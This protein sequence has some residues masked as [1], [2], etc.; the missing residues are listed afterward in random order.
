MRLSENP[1]VRTQLRLAR[2]YAFWPI[3]VIGALVAAAAVGSFAI[4]YAEKAA[5]T[6]TTARRLASYARGTYGIFFAFEMFVLAIG[7]TAAV[8][9]SVAQDRKAGIFDANRMTPLTPEA[10]AAGYW[11]G[12]IVPPVMLGAIPAAA[13]VSVAVIGRLGVLFAIQTQL[14]GIATALMLGLVGLVISLEVRR[15]STGA[16]LAALCFLGIPF[17][18][19][20][21]EDSIVAYLL[22]FIPLGEAFDHAQRELVGLPSMSIYAWSIPVMALALGLQAAVCA[23]LWPA[24]RRKFVDF[25]QPALTRGAFTL[26]VVLIAVVQHGLL[27]TKWGGAFPCR[28]LACDWPWSSRELLA[29]THGGLLVFSALVV[30]AMSWAP[31]HLRRAILRR[32]TTTRQIVLGGAVP[33]AVAI[34]VALAL[35][36]AVQMVLPAGV[37]GEARHAAALPIAVLD[38]MATLL[39]VAALAEY[40][41]LGSNAEAKRRGWLVFGL[42]LVIGAPLLVAL[43]VQ[44]EEFAYLSLGLTGIVAV[45]DSGSP[46]I[47]LSF[48]ALVLHFGAVAFVARLWIRSLSRRIVEI[49]ET[50]C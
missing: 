27:W 39:F 23:V 25:D 45:H 6:H 12:P 40:S 15:P 22:P 17:S 28:N 36:L 32:R 29:V 42:F 8:I 31:S 33:G 19:A 18:L 41:R 16:L 14:I 35:G 24:A 5:W 37:H 38:T 21:G 43:I 49:G 13:C 10:L 50:R 47:E 30:I 46:E 9:R 7:G 4:E 20:S 26:L 1:I 11:F 3:F 34:G 2:R 48:A 44:E